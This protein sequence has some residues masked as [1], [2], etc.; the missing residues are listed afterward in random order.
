MK[1]IFFLF[2]ITAI[3]LPISL[4]AFAESSAEYCTMMLYNNGEETKIEKKYED[5]GPILDKIF[6]DTFD[7]DLNILMSDKSVND[8]KNDGTHIEIFLEQPRIFKSKNSHMS[9]FGYK[10]YVVKDNSEK[11]S[12][13]VQKIFLTRQNLALAKGIGSL[14]TKPNIINID[15][16]RIKVITGDKTGYKSAPEFSFGVDEEYNKLLGFF[17]TDT[18]PMN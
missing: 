11:N 2:L 17:K 16:R 13:P 15:Q 14:E 6:L 5:V 10:T 18:S 9:Y 7:V 4:Q 1:K 8:M 3:L 12:L